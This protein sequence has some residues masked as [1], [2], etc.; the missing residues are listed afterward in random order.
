MNIKV[1]P[2]TLFNFDSNSEGEFEFRTIS[3]D[4]CMATIPNIG[5]MAILA[6]TVARLLIEDAV[7]SSHNAVE[8]DDTVVVSLFASLDPNDSKAHVPQTL[9]VKFSTP[10]EAMAQLYSAFEA[11]KDKFC[12]KNP[13]SFPPTTTAVYLFCMS[14]T[15]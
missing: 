12:L 15:M 2:G 3:D 13:R 14:S 11:E 4:T 7:H 8:I 10:G 5:R 6:E 1:M 9:G